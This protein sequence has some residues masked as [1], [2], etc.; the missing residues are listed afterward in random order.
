ML[1]LYLLLIII[2]IRRVITRHCEKRLVS[3]SHLEWL[4]KALALHS[5]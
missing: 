2:P 3:T 5:V 4:N 1:L